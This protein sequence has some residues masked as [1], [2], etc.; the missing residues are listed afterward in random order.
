MKSGRGSAFVHHQ[1]KSKS[2]FICTSGRIK[3][4][5]C[6][7]FAIAV[8]RGCEATASGARD[9]PSTMREKSDERKEYWKRGSSTAQRQRCAL[10]D[11]KGSWEASG[12]QAPAVSECV[13]MWCSVWGLFLEM[14]F[15]SVFACNSP[16]FDIFTLRR[17]SP[18]GCDN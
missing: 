8:L 9:S 17:Y 6:F 1:V 18:W 5:F 16:K 13:C 15:F 11:V 4:F 3:F 14:Y 10:F 12:R 7:V 2:S